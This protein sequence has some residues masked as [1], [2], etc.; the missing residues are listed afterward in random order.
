MNCR[1]QVGCLYGC[2][3]ATMF[4]ATGPVGRAAD[5]GGDGL[6]RHFVSP[7]ASARPLTCDKLDDETHVL[8]KRPF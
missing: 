3:V 8:A 1:Q 5:G 4:L 7:P 2:L 6:E